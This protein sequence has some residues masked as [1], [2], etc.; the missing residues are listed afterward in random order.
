MTIATL[1]HADTLESLA[2]TGE[3]NAWLDATSPT[4]EEQDKILHDMHVE[5]TARREREENTEFSMP[6]LEE[7]LTW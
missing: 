5:D 1:A 4:P 7:W 3:F 6:T 2:L